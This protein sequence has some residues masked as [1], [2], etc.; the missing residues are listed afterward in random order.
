MGFL[1]KHYDEMID[2]E[3]IRVNSCRR[4]EPKIAWSKNDESKYEFIFKKSFE[5]MMP[6]SGKSTGIAY[7]RQKGSIRLDIYYLRKKK[8]IDSKN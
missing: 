7:G 6:I 5:E 2:F 8:S 4:Q 1:P 3:T